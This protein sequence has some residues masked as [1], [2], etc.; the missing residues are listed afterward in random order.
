[1]IIGICHILVALRPKLDGCLPLLL[2]VLRRE[3]LAALLNTE[4]SASVC[5]RFA[6]NALDHKL[7]A[8]RV[9]VDTVR[10]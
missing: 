4:N 7:I 3:A 1:M 5:K 6:T 8:R 2:H 9:P 10:E